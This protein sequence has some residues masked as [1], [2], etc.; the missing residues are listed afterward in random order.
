MGSWS[1]PE[2]EANRDESGNAVGAP[3]N[4]GTVRSAMAGPPEGKVVPAGSCARVGPQA[5]LRNT[6][7][8]PV[9]S[10]SARSSWLSSIDSS[11]VGWLVGPVLKG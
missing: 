7:T 4:A 2:Y 1:G 11:S 10:T 8:P 9:T 3:V 6:A 5:A